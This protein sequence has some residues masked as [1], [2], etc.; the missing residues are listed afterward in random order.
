MA[1]LPD[2]DSRPSHFHWNYAAFVIEESFSW[3]ALT[4]AGISSVLPAFA[5]QLTSSEPLIGLTGTIYY[6]GW[7]L[8]QVLFGRLLAGRRRKKPAMLVGLIGR[9]GFWV[10][11]LTLLLRPQLQPAQMLALLYVCLGVWIVMDALVSLA[12]ADIVARAIPLDRRGSMM[13]LGQFLAGV[14][15][16]GAGAL[17]GVILVAPGISFPTNYALLFVL[18]GALFM[19]GAAALASIREPDPL[20]VQEEREQQQSGR[21]WLRAV[22]GDRVFRRFIVGRILTGV[23]NMAIPF[24]VGHAQQVLHLSDATIGVFAIAQT[25]A[26]LASGLGLGLISDRRGPRAVIWIGGLAGLAAPLYALVTHLCG[27][28]L[29]VW[30]Y[31]TVFVFLGISASSTWPGFFNY[32]LSV[33]P[34]DG[35]ATYVG[36]ANTIAGLLTLGPVLGGWLLQASSHTVLFSAALMLVG[37]GFLVT[38]GL[39]PLAP[40][41]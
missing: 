5:R 9:A 35:R 6:G 29:L 38:L 7:Y 22:A 11:G 10:L 34:D 12:W 2:R 13:G 1:E 19:P 4:F 21:S 3:L 16:I 8:P 30:A 36:L 25:V 28:P 23:G 26:S 24:Y 15:G 39:R 27:A 17:V 31:P 18:A 41:R 20:P 14:G 32:L 40:S 33:A 37:V